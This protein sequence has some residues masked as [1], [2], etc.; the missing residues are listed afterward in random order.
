MEFTGP[1]GSIPN[2][3]NN[4]SISILEWNRKRNGIRIC[5]WCEMKNHLRFHS[6]FLLRAC[7]ASAFRPVLLTLVLDRPLSVWPFPF[8]PNPLCCWTAERIRD[9]RSNAEKVNVCV[10]VWFMWFGLTTANNLTSNV[11]W[12]DVTWRGAVDGNNCF[13]FSI[14]CF[15]FVG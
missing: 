9:D 12:R 7:A 14:F 8:F 5:F 2:Y 13:C 10:C 6:D 4:R 1:Y 15:V 11:T 3:Y